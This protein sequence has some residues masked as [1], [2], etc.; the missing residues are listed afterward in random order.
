[1]LASAVT[2]GRAQETAGADE[3]RSLEVTFGPSEIWAPDRVAV[4]A[5]HQCQSALF[6]C[7]QSVMTNAAASPD[8]VAFYHLTGWFLTDLQLA[9]DSSGEPTGPVQLGTILNPWRA[10][11]NEQLALV[12]GIPDVVYPEQAAES[13]SLGRD[14]DYADLKAEH[15][16]AMFWAPGPVIEEIATT[17]SGGQRFL[18]RYRVLDGCHACAILAYARLAFDFAPDGTFQGVRDL[19][20][21]MSSESADS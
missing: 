4:Q 10:N 17:E 1:M 14:P 8:S 11:E 19:N 6:A 16:D 2:M 18:L 15:P 5:L 13:I 7:V 20:L 12:G 3:G 21:D 9:V